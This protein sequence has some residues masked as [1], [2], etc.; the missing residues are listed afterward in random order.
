[1]FRARAADQ[2]HAVSTP[3][4]AWPVHG[5]PSKLIP[6]VVLAPGSDAVFSFTTPQRRR[7]SP[8]ALERLPGP[9]LTYQVRLFPVAHHDGLQPTQ[10]RVVR[11]Q[12]PQA[13]AGR[14]TV[15][16]LLHSTASER[17]LHRPSFNVHDTQDVRP[18]RV[19]PGR[20]TISDPGKIGPA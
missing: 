4:T 5:A 16:H 8:G 20:R 19:L 13:D 10:H 9:H 12:P 1:M 14:P 15:F 7:L 11:R 6:G 18:W 17:Y 2:A 3:G